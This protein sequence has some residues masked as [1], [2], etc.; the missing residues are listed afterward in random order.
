MQK[1]NNNVP[2]GVGTALIGQRTALFEPAVQITEYLG[3]Q[4]A[5]VRRVLVTPEHLRAQERVHRLGLGLIARHELH[6]EIERENFLQ[7]QRHV[8]NGRIGHGG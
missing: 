2:E 8:I 6:V 3:V 5:E 1:K 4:V 7:H